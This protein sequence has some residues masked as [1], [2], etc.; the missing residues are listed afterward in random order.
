MEELE[1]V[2]PGIILCL[3]AVA[4]STVIHKRFAVNAERGRWFDGPLGTRAI[5]TFHPAYVP[6]GK[7]TADGETVALFR[8]D[9]AAVGVGLRE[10][11]RLSRR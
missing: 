11:E 1:I 6:R 8:S 9:L 5:A 2:A 10:A 4:A 7:P 3:G